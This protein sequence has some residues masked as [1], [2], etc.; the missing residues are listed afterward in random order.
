M[1]RSSGRTRSV[2]A[3]LPNVL[4]VGGGANALD[5][6]TTALRINRCTLKI[7]NSATALA[8]RTLRHQ[9]PLTRLPTAINPIHDPKRLEWF[10]RTLPPIS[11]PF[12]PSHARNIYTS[13]KKLAHA[14][15]LQEVKKRRRPAR[16]CAIYRSVHALWE[17]LTVSSLVG[18]GQVDGPCGNLVVLR[19]DEPAL[20]RVD[21]LVRLSRVGGS[22]PAVSTTGREKG[23]RLSIQ[24]A[25]IGR[26]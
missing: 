18:P 16:L 2:S 26:R 7:G 10:L 11:L 1:R 9:P 6:E 19:G 23:A 4:G 24:I 8:P 13:S 21:H 17:S 22:L 15:P 20:P 3:P 25:I 12:P 5:V 14:R